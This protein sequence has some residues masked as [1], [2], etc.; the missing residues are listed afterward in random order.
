MTPDSRL[1]LRLRHNPV[2]L[3]F[4]AGPWR[5]AG[6]LLTYLVISGV[7]FAIC[8]AASTLAAVFALTVAAVPLLIAL[9]AVIRGCAGAE[10]WML[11][12]AYTS[13]VRGRY[14]APTESGLMPRARA[15]WTSGATWRDLGL[16]VGLW[17]PLFALSALVFAAWAILLGG[18]TMPLWYWAARGSCVGD[19]QA[20][21]ARG[22]LLGHFPHG[23]HGHGAWGLYV[24]TL[25]TALLAAAG[26]AVLF[27][28]ANYLL[29]GTARVHARIAR[30][31]LRAPGDPLA[32]V[33]DVLA[34]PGPLG[35]LGTARSYR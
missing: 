17:P 1:R 33:K 24:H 26:F 27:L 7:L 11:R 20:S 6:Y 29:V 15:R 8:L 31:L 30:S 21:N 3:A 25:P 18:V 13:P 16:L 23:P 32:P 4:S 12:Q 22:I 9:A 28:L 34:R 35:P 5:A 2:L 19:C 10:R 14:P